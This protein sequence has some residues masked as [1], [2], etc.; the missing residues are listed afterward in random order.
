MRAAAPQHDNVCA[1]IRAALGARSVVFVGLMGA[2][3]TAIGRKVAQILDLP[4]AD[5]DHEIE[6]A[7]RMT[8]AE[9][10]AEYGEAEFRALEQR[11]L[12][13]LLR[14]GPR[15][16]ST[17]GGA[18]M[19][20]E[21]RATIRALGVSVWLKAGLDVLMPRVLKRPSRP[22]LQVP[23][24]RSVMERLMMERYPVYAEADVTVMTRDDSK[25]AIAR[26]TIDS[27]DAYLARGRERERV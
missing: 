3:K 2:G 12:A 9:L 6:A 11:V 25:E 5:S 4:F 13:R 22:L 27:L 1:R 26:E 20:A 23:D 18:F 21:T 8:V 17:G 16:V 10:F 24:P 19:N 7:A 15:V 14:D